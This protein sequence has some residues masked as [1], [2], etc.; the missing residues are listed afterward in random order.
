MFDQNPRRCRGACRY[1]IR[2]KRQGE[3]GGEH[4]EFWCHDHYHQEFSIGP[5]LRRLD[6]EEG[7]E[8]FGVSE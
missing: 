1:A 3:P 6:L 4:N 2:C 8:Y 5:E 7:R